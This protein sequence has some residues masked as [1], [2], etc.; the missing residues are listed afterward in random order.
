MVD[1]FVAGSVGWETD[2]TLFC[3]LKSSQFIDGSDGAEN[4]VDF[5]KEKSGRHFLFLYLTE[6]CLNK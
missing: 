1:N 5:E 3:H 6:V 2:L 4:L